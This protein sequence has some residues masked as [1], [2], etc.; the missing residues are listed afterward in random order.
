VTD[1]DR[2]A[3]EQ[4]FHD[5]RFAE[6]ERAA[7]RFYSI[8]Q[9]SMDHLFAAV[10]DLPAGSNVLDFGCGAE[11]HMAIAAARRGHAATAFDLSPVAVEKARE[12]AAEHGVAERIEFH[13]LNAEDVR[14]PDGAYDAI[15]GTG[16][17]HHLDLPR[18]Y[19][20]LARL[21]KPR[22][23]AVFVEPLGHNPLVN[24]YR[25]RTPGQRTDDEHP[26]RVE[27]FELARSYFE[28]V[29]P[30]YFSLLSLATL[31][32]GRLRSSAKL[33]ARL[34]AADRAVFRRLPAAG[35]HAWL[36]ALDLRDPLRRA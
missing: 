12:R 18:A 2:Y 1:L 14:L 7:N 36:V 17:L 8:D 13:V 4:Q 33:I 6:D 28:R 19:S 25:R 32:V 26:L 23:R 31:P 22:G 3:R 29:E 5:E 11:A 10:A 16:I 20:E 35:R 21:L 24:L 27:D 34:D 15:L 30:T 9:A